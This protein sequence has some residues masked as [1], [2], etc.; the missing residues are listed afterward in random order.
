MSS[1]TLS[2]T[3]SFAPSF[4]QDFFKPWNEW[5]DEDA[6]SKTLTVPAVNV[7]EE[8]DNYM[9]ALAAPGMKKEDFTIEVEG[10]LLTISAAKEDSQ[11]E[12]NKKYSRKE[13]HYAS[14]TR[15]FTL[16]ELVNRDKIE[17]NYTDGV[18]NIALPKLKDEKKST[19]QKV[20]VN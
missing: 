9:V 19:V 5:F 20:N 4:F 3:R 10:D 2:R 18:L 15:S 8:A 7:T 6:L 14:F 17:A 13:Y 16:P 11:E 12:K 1:K